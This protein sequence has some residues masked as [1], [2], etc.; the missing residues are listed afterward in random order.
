MHFDAARE[1]E[2]PVETVA[3]ARALVGY[4]LVHD[5]PWGR[6][7]GRIVETEA[8]PP[9]DPASHA[10]RGRRPRNAAMFGEPFHAYVYR[11][12]GVHDCFNITSEPAE[13]GAAVL[14][15]A[16]EPLAGLEVMRERVGIAA[17]QDLCRGPGRLARALGL[18]RTLDGGALLLPGP[19]WLARPARPASEIGVT[20]RIGITRA[21]E[22]PLRFYERS[23]RSV[24]GPRRLSP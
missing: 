7:A 6:L 9:G 13:V 8:Y 3:L 19:L 16:L 14:I 5:G 24:S 10:Y 4:I 23:T 20:P 21:A 1:G 17:E 2:L 18:D 15:R 22:R 11:I 12:Y